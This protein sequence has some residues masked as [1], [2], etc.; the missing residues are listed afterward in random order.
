MHFSKKQS[1]ID[2]LKEQDFKWC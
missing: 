1:S 2:F